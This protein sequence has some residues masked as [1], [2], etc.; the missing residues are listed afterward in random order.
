MLFIKNQCSN[1]FYLM[2]IIIFCLLS[3]FLLT[4][5]ENLSIRNPT[6]YMDHV[7]MNMSIWLLFCYSGVWLI[8]MLTQS[9]YKCVRV[10][11]S[12]Q[13]DRQTAP[14]IDTSASLI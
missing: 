6:R 1:R 4:P 9:P 3:V 13:T 8:M 12:D 2:G 5:Y 7:H 11:A 14:N 10:G